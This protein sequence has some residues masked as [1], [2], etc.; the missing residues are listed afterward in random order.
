[1]V[2]WA[3]ENNKQKYHMVK[4]FEI[5]KPKVQGGLGV[6]SSKRMNIALLSKWL[7]QIQTEEGGMWLQ[8][9]RR[10]YLRGQPPAFA[11]RAGGSQ[12]WQ[13]VISLLPVLRIGTSI[14]IGSGSA[15]LFWLDRWA[16]P[17]PLAERFFALFSICVRP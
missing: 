5:C 16:G 10:K 8:I 1:M 4:W 3:G 15:T 13:S 11:S 12:F 17:R 14:Q 7:W 2:F 6:I 9:I